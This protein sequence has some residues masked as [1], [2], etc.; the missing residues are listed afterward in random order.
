VIEAEV[1]E[2]RP[3]IAMNLMG[4]S[5]WGLIVGYDDRV[6]L[7]DEAGEVQGKRYLCR[8]Y[9][10]PPGADYRRPLLF[11]WDVYAVSRAGKALPTE[12]ALGDSLRRA[13]HL[14]EEKSG[15]AERPTGWMYFFR[16]EYASGLHAYDAWIA[17]LR[18]EEGI[19]RMTPAQ[20]VMYWQGHAVMYDQLHDARRAAEAYL[21]RSAAQIGDPKAAVLREAAD[22]YQDLVR[23]MTARWEC[24]P[25]LEGGYVEPET[26]WWLPVKTEEFLGARIPAYAAEW[27]PDMRRAGADLLESLRQKEEGALAALRALG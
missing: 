13:V 15:R 8:T 16:P 19:R 18:D 25:F 20:S 6:P 26:G 23:E 3:L 1:A 21:R 27:T 4:G 7:R 5:R 22:V 11:P 2:G 24:F 10:D 17:D 14:L 12:T 9:Y